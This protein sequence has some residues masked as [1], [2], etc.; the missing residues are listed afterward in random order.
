MGDAD[1]ASVFST[2]PP[3]SERIA[4]LEKFLPAVERYASQPQLEGRFR[5]VV[6]A[7]K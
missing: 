3:P 4:E 2:H 1:A 7:A 5:Q 6:G